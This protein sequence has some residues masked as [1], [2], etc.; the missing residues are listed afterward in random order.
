MDNGIKVSVFMIT[1]NHEKYLEQAL[2]SVV[3]QKTNFKFDV[4]VG[5]DYSTDKTR[6]IMRRFKQKYPDII[7]PI[8]RSQ[9][10]GASRNVVSVLRRC[11]GQYVAFLEGDD[12]WVDEYKLQKQVDFLEAR[13]DYC[14]VMTGVRVVDRYG[15]PM[16]TGPKLLD[17]ELATPLDFVK[18]MYPY[19]QFKFLGSLMCRNI[20]TDRKYEKYLLQTKIVTDQILVAAIVQN[21]KL[22]FMEEVLSAY[23]WVP[24]HADNYSAQKTENMCIDRIKSFRTV[25]MMYKPETYRWLY[26][27]ISRDYWQLLQKYLYEK[28]Y[29]ALLKTWFKS[30]TIT[31]RIFYIVYYAIRKTTGVY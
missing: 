27:R 21:G 1:Y 15:S 19:N 18:T 16:V 8:F 23:R 25:I 12:Y 5:D 9:N 11:T 31:E 4:I 17:H 20:W 22:G 13:P 29:K 3:S 26:M 10:L 7:K 28:D 2:E 6:T 14:G 30:M 24:S